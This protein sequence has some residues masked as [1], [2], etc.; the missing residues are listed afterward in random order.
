L[1]RL[2][3]RRAQRRHIL[4]TGRLQSANTEKSML[5]A[6]VGWLMGEYHAAKPETRPHWK[7]RLID[8]AHEM[9]EEAR[10]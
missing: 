7:K 2:P 6:V 8:L 5:N 3:A 10:K 1:P 4:Y 9:N